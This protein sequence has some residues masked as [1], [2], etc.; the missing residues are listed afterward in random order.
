MKKS[1]MLFFAA[2]MTAILIAGCGKSKAQLEQEMAAVAQQAALAEKIT[3][4]EARIKRLED[5]QNPR[6]AR[7]NLARK[8]YDARLEQDGKA[9]G[10]DGLRECE[11]LFR[12]ASKKANVATVRSALKILLSK[13]PKANST[14]CL[15]LYLGNFSRGAEKEKVLKQVIADYNDC[16]FS[17]GALTG[18]LARYN[19]ALYYL[20]AG[21][22]AEA[23]ALFQ[24]LRQ[25]YPEAVDHRNNL[26]RDLMPQP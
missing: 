10:M 15:M 22:K 7:F 11:K 1:L 4:L 8:Y 14:G 16:C 26:L 23:D 20:A 3:Q 9:Y 12:I 13:Y 25:N 6:E 19:L 21:K 5:S 17:D 24:D 18:A 2:L